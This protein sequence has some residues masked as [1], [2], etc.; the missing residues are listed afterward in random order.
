MT[1]TVRLGNQTQTWGY[2][3]ATKIE[4]LVRELAS[5]EKPANSVFH[6]IM[7]PFEIIKKDNRW[8]V[9]TTSLYPTKYLWGQWNVR[10]KCL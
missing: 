4:K 7:L 5:E 6:T 2:S 1:P 10:V 9:N 8:Q 3:H